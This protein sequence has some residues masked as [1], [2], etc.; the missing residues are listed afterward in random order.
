MN[1]KKED[2]EDKLY[3]FGLLLMATFMPESKLLM[4]ISQFF[5]ATGWFIGGNIVGKL[6]SFVRN[7]TAIIITL[8]FLLHLFGLIYTEDFNYALKD[9]RI[10]L[11]L[12]IFPLIVSTS[13][14]I[15]QKKFDTLLFLFCGSVFYATIY[16]VIVLKGW[17]HHQIH[18]IREISVYM[19]HIRF[20]L[21]IAFAVVILL[22]FIYKNYRTYKPVYTFGIAA[23]IIWFLVFL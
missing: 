20:G 6:K 4:S 21:M 10:K 9:L 18:D 22:Y 5:L 3:F 14:T 19:S 7:K 2:L 23:A 13:R 15:S 16:S 8:I 17:T 11:P 1:L 12:L